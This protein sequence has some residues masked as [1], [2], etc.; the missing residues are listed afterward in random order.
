MRRLLA[1]FFVEATKEKAY[2]IVHELKGTPV[3]LVD[4]VQRAEDWDDQAWRV[5]VETICQE[6]EVRRLVPLVH[7]L[8]GEAVQLVKDGAWAALRRELRAREEQA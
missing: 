6:L 8:T 3:L 2:P 4:A 1:E 7:M 5:L